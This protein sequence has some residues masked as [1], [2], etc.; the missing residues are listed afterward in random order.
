MGIGPPRL[1]CGSG[2]G[3]LR[4]TFWLAVFCQC[5]FAGKHFFVY[6]FSIFKFFRKN[7]IYI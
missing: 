2:W 7:A 4:P 5:L 1:G 3:R 6:E